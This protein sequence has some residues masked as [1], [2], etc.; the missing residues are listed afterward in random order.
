MKTA[1]LS[2]ENEQVSRHLHA[3][4]LSRA[5]VSIVFQSLILHLALYGPQT[6]TSLLHSIVK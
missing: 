1:I 6:L 3:A 5:H 4:G 2:G